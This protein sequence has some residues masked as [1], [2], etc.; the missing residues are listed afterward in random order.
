MKN[1]SFIKI[2]LLV[3]ISSFFYCKQDKSENK[4]TKLV[5]NEAKEPEKIDSTNQELQILP[6][7][8]EL[9]RDD[10]AKYYPKVADD[11]K[12]IRIFG[13]E[14]IDLN[15]GNEILVSLLHNTGTFDEIIICTHNK[16]LVLID[17]LYIG[18]ATDF[19]NGKSHT[20][21]SEINQHEIIFHQ[22]D[23]GFVKNG[24]EEEID[25]IKYEKW[26]VS[27][28]NDGRIIHHRTL[29]NSNKIGEKLFGKSDSLFTLD[30]IDTENF[31]KINA[32]KNT[33]FSLPDKSAKIEPFKFADFN[34]DRKG[35]ILVYLGAC[36]TGG[37]MYGLFLNQY[38]NYYELA[39]MDYLKNP[40]FEKERNGFFAIKS[41]EEIEPY[42][43]SKLNVSIFRFESNEYQLDTTFVYDDK[44]DGE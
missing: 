21:E 35:D 7:H 32:P 39:F 22:V 36:G 9:D 44:N 2:I 43:P 23:W 14:K 4:T 37:C 19:D 30:I 1:K 41:F 28:R 40:T 17:H 34:G 29:P 31:I 42:N 16:K 6:I 18:K 20:I 12:D 24:N 3:L 26:M 10:L 33:D 38:D 27:I 25:T 8:G 5:A 11:I 13:S 15:S